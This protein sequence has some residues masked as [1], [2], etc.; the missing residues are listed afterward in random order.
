MIKITLGA[1]IKEYRTVHALSMDDFSALSGI[2]KAY[3]S[4]LEK[5]KHPKTGKPI[6]PSIQII[7]QAS[8]AMNIDFNTLFSMIDGNVSLNN[9]EKLPKEFFVKYTNLRPIEK[10]TLPMLGSVACGKPI[11]ISEERESYVE[12]GTEVKADYCL[13]A[14]GDSMINARINDGD[15]IFVRQQPT[16][17]NGEIAVVAVDDEATLKRVYYY[18]ETQKL[19]LQAENPAYAPLLFVGDELE[20]VHILGKAVALQ[21]DVK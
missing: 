9:K 19:V 17:E 5:N 3:I 4:L 21:T 15:I 18:P 10:K 12:V 16:V 13:R 1:I 2:S 6:V 7:K 8:D 20:K 11:F 14:K